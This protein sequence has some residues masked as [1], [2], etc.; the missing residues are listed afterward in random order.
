MKKLRNKLTSVDF[1]VAK[2]YGIAV[3]FLQLYRSFRD[4]FTLFSLQADADWYEGDHNPQI[5][6][7]LIVLNLVII[8]IILY[9]IHHVEDEGIIQK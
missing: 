8:D 4:G 2:N 3:S 1:L 6:L 7:S 9:N 5:F